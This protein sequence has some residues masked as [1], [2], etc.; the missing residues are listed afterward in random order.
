MVKSKIRTTVAN[1][2]AAVAKSPATDVDVMPDCL[3]IA[4]FCR[5]NSLSVQMFYKSP[6]EMPDT[7]RLGARRLIT[8]EAAAR[9]RMARDA[10][11]ADHRKRQ[12]SKRA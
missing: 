12:P 4:E 11:A 8:R 6:G 9:W 10:Q 2:P 1:R 5:R 3:S 7:F